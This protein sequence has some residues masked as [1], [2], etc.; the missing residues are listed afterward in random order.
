MILFMPFPSSLPL[1]WH[2]VE[3]LSYLGKG[4]SPGPQLPNPSLSCRFPVQ[5]SRLGGESLA[6]DL[7]VSGPGPISQ[8][9]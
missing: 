9:E 7:Y 1:I 3:L 6:P 2:M 8:R 4:V 5:L